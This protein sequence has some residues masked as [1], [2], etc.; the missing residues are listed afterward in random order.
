MNMSFHSHVD[1]TH[2]HMKGFARKFALKKRRK[3]VRK[4]PIRNPL[5]ATPWACLARS[6]SRPMSQICV[7][8]TLGMEVSFHVTCN[9]LL[10]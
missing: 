7:G 1:K 8:G 5:R 9:N 2:F 3:T 10:Y 4:W 6:N